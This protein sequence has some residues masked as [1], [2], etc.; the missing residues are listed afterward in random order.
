M[1]EKRSTSGGAG[2][3][4]RA[5]ARAGGR[6]GAAGGN[7]PAGPAEP[8]ARKRTPPGRRGQP[9]LK[10]DL[11]D[12]A[13][14]R[15]NGWSHD[16][17]LNFLENLHEQGHNINDREA[18]GIALEKERLDIVL[19]KVKGVGPRRRQ[20]LVNHFD[21]LWSLRNASVEEI[22]SAGGL[23]RSLAEKVREEVEH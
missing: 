10:R 16:D 22:A 13:A 21:N 4:P 5:G 12:F 14:A 23:P 15:P 1:P 18:I 9:D 6:K 7:G 17:W 8:G 20:A 3:E 2:T 19:E 11:R